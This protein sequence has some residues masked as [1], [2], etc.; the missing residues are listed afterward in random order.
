MIYCACGLA[1]TAVLMVWVHGYVDNLEKRPPSPMVDHTEGLGFYPVE[2]FK[3]LVRSSN[4][5]STS[6]RG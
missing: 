1:Q 6:D 4:A 5:S 2:H 3:N